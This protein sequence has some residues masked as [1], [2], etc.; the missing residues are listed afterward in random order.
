VVFLD[1]DLGQPEFTPAGLV[2]LHVISS[3]VFGPSFMHL[4]SPLK[5]VSSPA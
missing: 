4:A 2:S 3:P 5:C 1:T